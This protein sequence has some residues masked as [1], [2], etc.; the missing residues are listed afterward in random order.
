MKVII[1]PF[2]KRVLVL[3]KKE[4][5]ELYYEHVD[6]WLS[7]TLN[8]QVYDIHILYDSGLDVSTY[9]VI[10]GVVDYENS[11]KSTVKIVY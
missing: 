10:D 3:D 1:N 5:V 2:T 11:V 9:N 4:E 7:F 6:E 8:N